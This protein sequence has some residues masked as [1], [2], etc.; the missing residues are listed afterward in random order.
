MA[1]SMR[2]RIDSD[3][4]RIDSSCSINSRARSVSDQSSATAD[5]C[6]S[7]GPNRQ[8]G[9]RPSRSHDRG[10]LY[11]GAQWG[12]WASLRPASPC[13]ATFPA[14][15]IPDLEFATSL[16]SPGPQQNGNAAWRKGPSS[17]DDRLERLAVVDGFK[18]APRAYQADAI[19]EVST[20]RRSDLL[21]ASGEEPWG[22]R[23]SGKL[24]WLWHPPHVPCT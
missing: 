8:C 2:P 16:E 11:I 6:A 22:L 9:R 14:L 12:W 4:R 24:Q 7:G 13:V 17:L 5:S 10:A 15:E 19:Y 21:A 23:R 20:E 18:P 3:S 1:S